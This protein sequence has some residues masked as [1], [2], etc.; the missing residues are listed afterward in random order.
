LD[1]FRKPQLVHIVGEW[2]LDANFFQ[3]FWMFE[4]Q[5]SGMKTAAL[6]ASLLDAEICRGLCFPIV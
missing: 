5:R 4:S 1:L 6:K 2:N 3:S